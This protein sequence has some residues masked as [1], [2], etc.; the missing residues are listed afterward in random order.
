MS[1][2]DAQ[3]NYLINY[4]AEHVEDFKMLQYY[5][6]ERIEESMRSTS[7]DSIESEEIYESQHSHDV[8][9]K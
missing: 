6:N 5:V 3:F 7:Y 1:M 4:F 2:S 9:D 8:D